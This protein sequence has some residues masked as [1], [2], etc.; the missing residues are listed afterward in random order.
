ML[1]FR[2]FLKS[3]GDVVVG[4]FLLDVVDVFVDGCGVVMVMVMLGLVVVSRVKLRMVGGMFC[5]RLRVLL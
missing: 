3:G 4:G 5:V 2:N 1:S